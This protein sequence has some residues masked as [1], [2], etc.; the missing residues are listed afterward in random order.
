MAVCNKMTKDLSET[1][2]SAVIEW[3]YQMTL[4]SVLSE[5]NMDLQKNKSK[6]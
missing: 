3:H 6:N 4:A 5:N 1:D 2:I